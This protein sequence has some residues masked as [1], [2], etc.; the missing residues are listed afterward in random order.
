MRDVYDI[1]TSEKSNFT[2]EKPNNSMFGFSVVNHEDSGKS[3]FTE[4]A[5]EILNSIS[6]TI[7]FLEDWEEKH[8]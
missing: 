7:K 6:E 3:F 8:K 5:T 1:I 4:K 2:M